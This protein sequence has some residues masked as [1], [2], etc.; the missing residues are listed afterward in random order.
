MSGPVVGGGGCCGCAGSAVPHDVD[1]VYGRRDVY[2]AAGVEM[3]RFHVRGRPRDQD[4]AASRRWIITGR[5]SEVVAVRGEGTGGSDIVPAGEIDRVAA[6]G[7]D[8][9]PGPASLPSGDRLRGGRHRGPPAAPDL[10]VLGGALGR[11]KPYVLEAV[12]FVASRPGGHGAVRRSSNP[13]PFAR[14]VDSVTG[15]YFSEGAAR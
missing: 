2:D 8:P 1:G 10:R 11:R 7:G 14:F 5:T 4:V 13:P 6:W 3:K 12:H 15:K 9:G